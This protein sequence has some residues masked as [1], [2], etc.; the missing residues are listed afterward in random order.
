MPRFKLILQD[1]SGKSRTAT[2][3]A[4]SQ[5]EA[6]DLARRKGYQVR[7]IEP[8]YDL[9][10]AGPPAPMDTAEHGYD[11]EDLPK[12]KTRERFRE[13]GRS[14]SGFPLVPTILSGLALA[15]ALFTLI[16]V[17]A[18]DPLGSGLGKYDFTSPRATFKS[19]LEMEK[20]ADVRAEIQYM[21]KFRDK[22]PKG[23][24]VAEE[25]ESYR[26]RKEVDFGSKK[27]LFITVKV[28]G[29]EQH[30]VHW[31][32][33]D[34]ESGYWIEADVSQAALQKEQPETA[35]AISKFLASGEVSTK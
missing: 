22:T 2:V 3:E 1:A 17:L 13:G 7:Q 30:S 27:A 9:D 8:V 28:N 11:D 25:L 31:Y 19:Q 20:N 21:R 29:R 6:V 33:K 34:S 4:A 18:S 16:Y 23:K 5:A 35:E 24:R 32:E 14:G 15:V 12:K 26:V 10:D